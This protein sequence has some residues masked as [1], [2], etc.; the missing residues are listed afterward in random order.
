MDRAREVGRKGRNL[1]K[2]DKLSRH[3]TLVDEDGADDK[4]TKKSVKFG[5][6][7]SQPLSDYDPLENIPEEYRNHGVDTEPM[8]HYIRERNEDEDL[9]RL[10]EAAQRDV[11]LHQARIKAAAANDTSLLAEYD[12]TKDPHFI[13]RQD[14]QRIRMEDVK[15]LTSE[16]NKIICELDEDKKNLT[17]TERTQVK[18]ARWQRALELYVYCPSSISMDLL[19]LLEK[20]LDGTSE[21]RKKY[22][23]ESKKCLNGSQASYSR[24][25]SCRRYC[26]K[27]I[28]C[29]LRW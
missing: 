8:L 25:K 29:V 10:L 16:A 17:H 5:E 6:S 9:E 15:S 3:R 27:P 23:I 1:P 4:Q 26:P 21:V 2:S 11:R 28:T 7:P 22:K 13:A 24:R 14:R 18:L 12:F 20:L 19:G